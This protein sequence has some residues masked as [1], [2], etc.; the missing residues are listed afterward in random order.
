MTLE[1]ALTAAVVALAGCV[2]A[3]FAWFKGQFAYVVDKLD[4][5]E[6]DREALWTR[7]ANLAAGGSLDDTDLSPHRD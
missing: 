2:G 5:C 7:V 1:Q 6:R 4:E 3:L